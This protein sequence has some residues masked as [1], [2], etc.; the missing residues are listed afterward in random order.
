ITDRDSHFRGEVKNVVYP[1]VAPM[2]GFKGGASQRVQDA[3]IARVRAL[4]DDFGF[5]YRK[6]SRDGTRK[7]LFKAKIIQ[8]AINHL[9]FRNK[10][11]EGIKYPEFYQPIPETGLALILTAV[12]PHMSFCLRHTEFP[13]LTD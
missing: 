5:V 11:D 2:L 6:L 8:S 10:K 9:W 12:R 7:G 4:L 3:N 1:L 13:S